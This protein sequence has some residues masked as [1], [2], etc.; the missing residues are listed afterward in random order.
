MGREVFPERCASFSAAGV[1]FHF[2]LLSFQALKADKGHGCFK[3]FHCVL[4]QI[5]GIAFD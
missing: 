1:G 2:W 5:K 4:P 3:G